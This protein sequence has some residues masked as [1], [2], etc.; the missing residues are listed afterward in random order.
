[1]M[2]DA[3]AESDANGDPIFASFM[4]EPQEVDFTDGDIDASLTMDIF[5]A[6]D[7]PLVPSMWQETIDK[8]IIDQLMKLKIYRVLFS[9]I[10]RGGL[11]AGNEFLRW[12]RGKLDA[13]IDGAG[14]MTLA[15][16]NAAT[17]A[18]LSVVAS[19]TTAREMMVLNHRTAPDCPVAWAVR[20]S[21]S[22]PFAWQEVRWNKDWGTYMDRDI[23]G[24]TVVDGGALSNFPIEL[25]TSKTPQVLRFMGDETDPDLN[26][27]IGLLIDEEIEVADAGTAPDDDGKESGVSTDI[28]DP[29]FNIKKLRTVRRVQRLLNTMTDA[30]DAMVMAA[31]ADQ[32]CRLPAKTYGT[33][34][35]DMTVARRQALVAA[36]ERAMEEYLVELAHGAQTPSGAT[37]ESAPASGTAG[38]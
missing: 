28:K 35:F 25:L 4:D 31:H 23:T 10:E 27:T 17:K 37:G 21:M 26:P 32:I 30:H 1:M 20:M 9:F 38:S 22:I 34:E 24:N 11:Y 19:N 36:G 12:F 14:N 29:K 3:L 5:R 33:M 13:A 16:F 15:D 6:I 8:K 2:Q 18:D 7:T